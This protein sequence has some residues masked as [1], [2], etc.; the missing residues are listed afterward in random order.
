MKLN[1][2]LDAATLEAISQRKSLFLDTSIWNRLAD[3]ETEQASRIRKKLKFL[4]AKERLF[5]PLAMP[6]IMEV[7]KQEGSSLERTVAI[8]EELSLNVS[9]C[10]I[11]TIFDREIKVFVA[12]LLSGQYCPLTAPDVFGP[13]DTYLGGTAYLS[14]YEHLPRDVVARLKGHL[15]IE[16][17]NLSL[18]GFLRLFDGKRAPEPLGK[19]KCQEASARRRKLANDSVRMMRRIEQ[20]E[21]AR[22][23]VIPKFQ[24]FT[25]HLAIEKR[26]KV[27]DALNRLPKSKRFGDAIASMLNYLPAV[28]AYV[29]VMTISGYDSGKKASMN[30]FFDCEFLIYG[31]S[32]ASAF[33]AKDSGMAEIVRVSAK[34]RQ[35]F[36]TLAFIMSLDELEI[37]LDTLSTET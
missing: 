27:I 11:K 1:I 21:I 17:R 19:L 20:E 3:C 24:E 32:Y 34:E 10:N 29:D 33:C 15:E 12:Y 18:S 35:H 36:G 37:Y 31:L 5:C 2:S 28:S 7:R 4:V 25:K 16:I 9:F 6:T 14:D 30:N 26:L 22:S 23:I 8:M 13:L